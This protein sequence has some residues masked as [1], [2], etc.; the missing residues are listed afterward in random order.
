[1][2]KRVCALCAFGLASSAMLLDGQDLFVLPGAQAGNGAVEAFV[3]NQGIGFYRSFAAGT[4]AFALL[5][6]A[7]GNLADTSYFVVSSSTMNSI[8]AFTNTFLS[9]TQV[10]ALPAPP[11]QAILT[12]SGALLVVLA[13]NIYMF[14]SL[15]YANLDPSGISQGTG[16]TTLSI[17]ASLDSTTIFALGSSGSGTSQLDAFNT[18]SLARAAAPLQLTEQA[19]AVTVGPNGLVY[20]SLPNE[21]LEVN[22]LT[23]QPTFNGAISLTGT[24]GPLVFTPDGQFAAGINESQSGNSLL[25]A[26]LPTHTA[27]S[28]TS[29][30]PAEVTLLQVMGIDELLAVSNS[31]LSRVTLSPLTQTVSTTP[32]TPLPNIG[33]GGVVA[34]TATNDVPAGTHFNVQSVFLA[35]LDSVYQYA[36]A[37]NSV[38]STYP[39]ENGITPGAITYAVPPITSEEAQP[40]ALLTLGN[41][42]TILPNA[43]SAPLVVQVLDSNSIPVSGY[44]VQFQLNGSGASLSATSA[45]SGTNGYAL[46]YLTAGDATGTYTVTATAG[47]APAANFS[48][49]VTPAAQNSGSVLLTIVAGQGQILA[50]NTSTSLGGGFGQSLEVS[51]TNTTGSPIS[52]L[53]V[54]FSIPAGDGTIQPQGG[55]TGAASLTVYTNSSGIAAVDFLATTLP[56]ADATQGFLQAPVTASAANATSA[57]FYITTVNSPNITPLAPQIGQTITG[58]EGTTLTGA[59]KVRVVSSTGVPIPNVSLMLSDNNTNPALAP[60]ATCN[61]P[62]GLV[63]SDATGIATC[64]VTFG[65]RIT[66]GQTPST[67]NE[68]VGITQSSDNPIRFIV[69]P[70]APAVVKIVQGNNQTGGAGQTLSGALLIHVT[71]SG[72]NTVSGAAVNWQVVTPGTATLSNVIGVTDSNGD[73]SALVT[74]GSTAGPVMVTATAGS[75]SATFTLTNNIPAAALHKVS[76][77]QQTATVSTPFNMPLTVQAVNSSGNGIGGLQIS[78]QVTSGVATLGSA[79][80]TTDSTG[81]A[82]TT[83]TAGATAGAITVTAT[84]ANFTVTF[85]LTAIPIGPASVTIVNGA[86]FDANTGISPGGIATIRG[87]G[88]LSGVTGILVATPNASGQYPTTFSGLTISFNGTPAPIYYVEAE[89]GTDQI[90]VQVPFEVQPGSSVSVEISAANLGSATVTAAVKMLAPGVFTTVY[91]GKVYAVAVRPDGSYV[92]P[93]N[94]AQQGEDIQIYVTGLGQASPA[95]A[96]NAPGEGQAVMSSLVVGLNNGGVPLVSAVYAPGLIGVYVVTLQ[97]PANTQTGPY[98]PVGI[99]ANDSQ[100]NQNFAQST[101]IPIQ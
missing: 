62:G 93:T 63:L 17:A 44:D 30:L 41:N 5:P 78:F 48:V 29:G 26:A 35:S 61:G 52:N 37:S 82:S 69:T 94:P 22:P 91:D 10:A 76:G 59:V 3:T 66:Q 53:P 58:A 88:M 25:I 24:P 80:V 79:T 8:E 47:S 43:M 73:A 54:T 21:I 95:L 46:T 14:S 85:N 75:A 60:T 7:T 34:V 38:V 70:G 68:I 31:T 100:G 40:T 74:L 16:I 98:Q 19:T 18:T 84:T 23:L 57:T 36:P 86:S 72:G 67:V 6:N 71:D 11:Q 13:G 12:P 27:I 9:P 49:N 81:Q 89:N 39:V 20:V 64:D 87:T 77:D 56:L 55:G 2:L 101:Y 97:V 45:V 4:G 96:T 50:P 42:Q 28:P 32:G 83:V 1:M 92:S 51:A 65:P 99:I 15:T 33:I 90:S